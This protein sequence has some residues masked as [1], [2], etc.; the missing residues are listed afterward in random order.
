MAEPAS[1]AAR[2]LSFRPQVANPTH[3]EKRLLSFRPISLALLAVL[4]LE[5]AAVGPRWPLRPL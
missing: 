2:L 5:L 3:R 4:W 1:C